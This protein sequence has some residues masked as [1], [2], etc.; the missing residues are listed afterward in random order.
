MNLNLGTIK[1]TGII[2]LLIRIFIYVISI[3][4]IGLLPYIFTPRSHLAFTLSF[5]L[6]V[7]LISV[8]TILVKDIN[9]FLSH[10]VPV[11]TPALL[12]PLIVLIESVRNVIRPITLSVRLAANIVAGHLLLSLIRGAGRVN[13]LSLLRLILAALVL[14]RILETAVAIIQSYVLTSLSRIYLGE[15]NT[16][17]S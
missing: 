8:M 2:S 3:N 17:N 4:V 13:N 14:I 6:M 1:R 16:I 7:W 10:L 15:V 12:I 11:G 5:G 9:F